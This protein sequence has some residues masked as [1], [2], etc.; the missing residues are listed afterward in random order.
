MDGERASAELVKSYYTESVRAEWRRLV[1]DAAHRVEL[2][3]TLHF[4]DQYLP[5][6]ARILDAGGGPGRY[7]IELA[8]RGHNLVLLDMTPANLEYARRQ[9]KRARVQQQVTGIVEGTIVDLAQ[10]ADA[11]FDAAVCLGGPLSHVLDATGRQRAVDE[12]LRV[13]RPG[14]I[15]A[16][17]V[18]GRLSVLALELMLF[19]E[20]IDMPVHA[21][22][23]ETG[24]YY[25]GSGFTACHFFLPEE[26][27]GLFVDKPAAIETMVGLEGLGSRADKAINRTARHP[28]RWQRWLETHYRT[29]THPA[30]VGMSEHMLVIARKEENN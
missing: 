22:I 9:I 24:S 2:E 1:K 4:L 17:S 23:R 5:P 8:R 3:T 21:Q 27:A 12:L 18:M 19:P 20:E 16:I 7:T 28:Q 6:Q 11:S 10:F 15:I 30:V 25:G 14:G 26:L 13:V 29:C